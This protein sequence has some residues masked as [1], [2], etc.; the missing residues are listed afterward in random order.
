MIGGRGIKCLGGGGMRQ[1]IGGNETNNWGEADD[2]G[3]GGPLS[4]D[5]GH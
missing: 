2:W 1:M 5:L 3:E 4:L